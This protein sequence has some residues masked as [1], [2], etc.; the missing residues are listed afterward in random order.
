MQLTIITQARVGYEMVG[1]QLGAKF[2]I[3]YTVLSNIENTPQNC[4]Y[5]LFFIFTIFLEHSTVV[6][7]IVGGDSDI[8]IMAELVILF[9]LMGFKK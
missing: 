6:H 2:L 8:K 4:M 9:T 1:S 5:T 3:N 7:I